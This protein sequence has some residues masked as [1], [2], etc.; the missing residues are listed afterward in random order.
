MKRQLPNILTALRLFSPLVIIPAAILGATNFAAIAAAGFGL[1]DLL[2]GKLAKAWNAQSELGA[3]LDAFTDKIFAGTL[4][5]A[6]AIF[7]PVLVGNIILE[8]AIAGI[9]LKQKFSGKES[10]S[11]QTGRVKTWFLFTLGALGLIAPAINL[12]PAVIPGLA[13]TTGV[14]QGLTI[15]SYVKNI[16]KLHRKV[17]NQKMTR[18]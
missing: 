13:L 11:T 10:K 4:L 8:M 5:I 1:T 18:Q 6:G 12:A 9:N 17:I 7:N 14:L 16:V 15:A 2:D 3:D